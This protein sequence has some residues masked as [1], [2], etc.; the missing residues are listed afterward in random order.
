MG[1]FF[2]SIFTVTTRKQILNLCMFIFLETQETGAMPK[3]Q[4]KLKGKVSMT[5]LKFIG[6]RVPMEGC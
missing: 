3:L 5:N 1:L 2:S 6:Q 4:R